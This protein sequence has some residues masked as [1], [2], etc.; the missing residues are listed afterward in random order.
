MGGGRGGALPSGATSPAHPPAHPTTIVAAIGRAAR[1]QPRRVRTDAASPSTS[2]RPTGGCHTGTDGEGAGRRRRGRR[3]GQKGP[4]DVAAAGA[5]RGP[6]VPGARG[7]AP[8]AEKHPTGVAGGRGRGETWPPA[9]CGRRGHV[10]DR[11]N[12]EAGRQRGGGGSGAGDAGA[13]PPTPMAGAGATAAPMVGARAVSASGGERRR[14]DRVA[15]ASPHTVVVGIR[16]G[17]GAGVLAPPP[18]RGR[19]CGCRWRKT[20]V[21]RGR[22]WWREVG[23]R[24]H[25]VLLCPLPQR[26]SPG[27]SRGSSPEENPIVRGCGRRKRSGSENGRFPWTMLRGSKPL[28]CIV[29]QL[30]T[31]SIQFFF[32]VDFEEQLLVGSTR[33]CSQAAHL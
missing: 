17:R 21:H 8:A 18:G 15:A 20:G 10:N 11:L 32:Q 25:S 19:G 16:H 33:C 31:E 3:K 28:K 30:R 23:G 24:R 27:G 29:P 2:P 6:T 26:G 5:R 12:G 9:T 22:R 1:A 4:P 13:P 7:E 14:P